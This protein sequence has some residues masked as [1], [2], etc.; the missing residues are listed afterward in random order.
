MREPRLKVLGQRLEGGAD[1]RRGAGDLARGDREALAR[2]QLHRLVVLQLAGADLRPLQIGENADRL[3]LL[4]RN[5]PDH[6]DQ[7]RFLRVRAMREVE[8]R[9]VHPC[10][11]QPA[12]DIGSAAGRT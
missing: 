7:L 4:G 3:A 10:P 6:L 11:H 12:K 2:D 1:Q 5:R 8:A 9:N